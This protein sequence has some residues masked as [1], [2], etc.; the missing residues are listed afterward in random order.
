MH[1]QTQRWEPPRIYS[2]DVQALQ[3]GTGATGVTDDPDRAMA[4]LRDQLEDAPDGAW[5]VV[6]RAMLSPSGSY[7]YGCVIATGQ[8]NPQTHAIT[9]WNRPDIRAQLHI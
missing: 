3:D 5:G 9:W 4:H 7:D 6:R 2:W 8:V 1:A